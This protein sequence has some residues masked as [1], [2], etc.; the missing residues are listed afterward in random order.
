VVWTGHDLPRVRAA[1]CRALG[2]VGDTEH[3]AVVREC[4]DDPHPDVRRAAAKAI[5]AMA[6]RL[7][8]DVDP[9][10]YE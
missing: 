1:A 7:D 9:A 10:D 8:L 5:G 3:L 4:L 2:A 6:R